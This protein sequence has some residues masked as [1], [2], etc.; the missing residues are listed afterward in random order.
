MADG[1]GISRTGFV[2]M[3]LES[4]INAPLDL[5]CA[6]HSQLTKKTFSELRKLICTVP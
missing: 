4:F 6:I 3:V 2:S 1:A 5:H